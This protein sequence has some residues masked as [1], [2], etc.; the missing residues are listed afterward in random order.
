M[1]KKIKFKKIKVYAHFI[2]L[3][4]FV[5]IVT[6][7]INF[8]DQYKKKQIEYLKKSLNN[9]YLHKSLKTITS[10]LKPRYI[11]I[12]FKIRYYFS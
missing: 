3:I 2:W 11:K 10:I 7:V 1:Y 8:H 9:I 4:I 6:L 5:T 12:P